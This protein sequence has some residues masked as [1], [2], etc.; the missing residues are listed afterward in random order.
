MAELEATLSAREFAEWVAFAEVHPFPA[1][2]VDMHGA[3]VAAILA[4]V[5][6]AADAPAAPLSDFLALRPRP[7]TPAKPTGKPLTESQ[8]I[9]AAMGR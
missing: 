9:R 5:H 6:R 7:A 1:D 4:N 3:M 2:L 8:R